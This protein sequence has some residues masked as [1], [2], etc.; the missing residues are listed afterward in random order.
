MITQKRVQI[1]NINIRPRQKP[2]KEINK[3]KKLNVM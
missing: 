1:N 3:A 2:H